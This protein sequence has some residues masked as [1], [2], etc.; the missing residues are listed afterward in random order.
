[1]KTRRRG[2]KWWNKE[3]ICCNSMQLSR[4]STVFFFIFF[5][6]SFS[7]PASVSFSLSALFLCGPELTVIPKQSALIQR[8]W[9]LEC[10]S[11][12]ERVLPQAHAGPVWRHAIG[13]AQP[14]QK[15]S[16]RGPFS[17]TP[18]STHPLNS[19]KINHRGLECAPWQDLQ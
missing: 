5:S 17:G 12:R 10:S 7:I 13:P 16:A 15:P 14:H 1:M 9:G 18:P 3:G 4:C 19:G 6:L 11:A 8:V 2:I